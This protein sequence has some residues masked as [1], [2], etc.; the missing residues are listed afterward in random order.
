MKKNI[1]KIY[2]GIFAFILFLPQFSSAAIISCGKTGENKMCTLCDLIIGINTIIKYI[3]SISVIA[4]LTALF[5]GAI[6][7]IFSGADPSSAEKGKKAIMNALLGIVI[8]FAAWVFVNFTMKL[9]GSKSN[10]GIEKIDSGWNNF[11]CTD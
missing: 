11:K 10:L 1:I 9:L 6:M 2:L 5:I 4:A 8:I 7:Y 3:F